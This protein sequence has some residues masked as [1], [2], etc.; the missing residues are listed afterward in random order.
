MKIAIDISPLQSG[1]KVRGVGFY[2]TNLKDALQR[3]YPHNNYV[4]FS[5]KE[6]IPTTVDLVH[7]PYFDPFFL[8]LPFIKRH[9]TVVTVHDLTPIVFPEHFPAGVKGKIRWQIQKQALRM[10]DAIITDSYSS[11]KDIVNYA[12]ISEKKISV[13]YLAAGDEF[14]QY[15]VSKVQY[16]VLHEKYNLP[17][18]FIL[19]VGDA[20][21]NKNLV[22]L[23]KAV[24]QGDIPL[25]MVGKAMKDV[26]IDRSNLWNK[27][28]R[29]VQDMIRDDKQFTVLGFVST[30]DLVLLYNLAELSVF[31][32]FYEGFGLPVLEAMACGCPVV[33]SDK[34]SLAEVVGDAAYI[35]DPYSVEG[36]AKGIAE[37]A[38][39]KDL[40][41]RLVKAGLEQAKKFSWKKTALGTMGVYETVLSR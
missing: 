15:D 23:V 12:G 6:E 13:V 3:F 4:F 26:D 30:E 22:N 37:V 18:K 14:R 28:L 10:T 16:Q 1:H 29:E 7:F 25:V 36:I 5:S 27:D 19:Y 38:V 11:K 8:T 2:L 31:P 17:K 34:G 35:V 32:S 33:T 9:K 24:R 21:W 20:T 41:N 40:R 39:K